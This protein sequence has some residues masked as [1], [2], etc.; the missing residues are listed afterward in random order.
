[1]SADDDPTLSAIT[2]S[3][4]LESETANPSFERENTPGDVRRRLALVPASTVVLT[5]MLRLPEGFDIRGAHA[6]FTMDG[7]SFVVQS[8]SFEVQPEGVVLPRLNIEY[9]ECEACGGP[10]FD[11][12]NADWFGRLSW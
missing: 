4:N 12:M 5:R 8:P 10:V 6:D 1:M 9:H 2:P 7:V 3:R 11:G